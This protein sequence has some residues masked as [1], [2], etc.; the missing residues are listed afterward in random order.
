MRLILISIAIILFTLSS[1]SQVW[2]D[3]LLNT[4]PNATF[5][6]KEK[7]FNEY[8][9]K[10]P[11]TK[12]NG[13]KPYARDIFFL[14]S[15]MPNSG[16]FPS[17]ALYTEWLKEKEKYSKYVSSSNWQALGPIDVPIILSNGKNRG[18][19]RINAIAFDPF[20]ANII[21]VGSPGGGFWK[22]IDGGS[23]WQ[24]FTDNLPVIG[25][26]SI[27]VNPQDPDIIYIA[28]GDANGSDTYS[29]GVMKS[30]DAGV[31]WNTTGLSYNVSDGKKVNKIIIN[32]NHPDSLFAATNAN[33][34]LSTDGGT[35]WSTSGPLGRWRDIEFKPNNSNIIFAARQSNGGSNVYRSM[36]GGQN[37]YIVNNGVSSTGKYRPLIA[38]TPA[39]P[40]VVYALYSSADHGFHGIYKSIDGG[41]NWSLQS[42]SPNILGRA[43][44][45]TSTGGQ[46]W[47]DLSL[48]VSTVNESHLYIGG[49]N[50][51][52]STDGGQSWNIEGSSGSGSNYSYMHVDQHCLEFNPINNI[53]YAG[54]DGGLYK[55]MQSLNKWVDISDGLEISQFYRLGLSKSN[56]NRL[57]AGAQDN[58]TEM[59]TSGTWD[60]I[61]GADGMEC[62]IDPF[63]QDLI[64]SASQYGGIKKSYNGGQNWDNIKPVSY[65]GAWVTP[66][67][68]HPQNNNLIVAG[69]NEV[70]LS[71]TSGAV[72]DSISFNVSNGQSLRTIALAPSDE[73]YI[74]AATYTLFKMSSDGGISW[75]NIKPGLPANSITDITVS[76][77][78]PQRLWVTFSGYTSNEKIYESVDGGNNWNNISGSNLPNL[79]VNC[80]IHQ[81]FSN[82]DLYLGT[83]VGVY[84]KNNT[85]SDWVPFMNGLPNVIIN[86]LEIQYS[87]GVIRAA[88]Y[89][90]GIWESPL[91]TLP[92]M[93]VNHELNSIDFF[94]NPANNIFNIVIPEFNFSNY[95][96]KVYS[97]T[98][99][100]VLKKTI[101]SPKTSIDI[102]RLKRGCYIVSV[103]SGEFTVRKKLI[104]N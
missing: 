86:E 55:Y 10:S 22:S 8:R 7:A 70:Y 62:I 65:E 80:V 48:G 23:N 58:G 77:I 31:T 35:S 13:Y 34:M 102:S 64:Y 69:Y 73:N 29:I 17:T 83:D 20:D 76:H 18:N 6:D 59:L 24:T 42:N 61:R 11:I 71:K 37:W 44:D 33:L 3:V 46:S 79:P 63:D 43:T 40:N 90:R 47:Y 68:M 2:E 100:V 21:Y 38:V 15:R 49:I 32:P 4:Y 60:A 5:F 12:G 14:S 26:S 91:Q 45:G 99:E 67:E 56:A 98:G 66:Y 103:S 81:D 52:E 78:N 28:T 93:T 54:N 41:S 89:G 87:I 16:V 72:W 27:A 75:T 96:I 50:L 9:A 85:M 97:L 36:D 92:N 1:K 53:A 74:Y 104:I 82:D 39:N 25:V 84:Y 94:P 19:G 30:L 101:N 57:V 51:W 95:N 88:T